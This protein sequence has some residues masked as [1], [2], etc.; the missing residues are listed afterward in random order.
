MIIDKKLVQDI[1]HLG[2]LE[3]SPA[4]EEEMANELNKI[5]DWMEQLNEVDTT[6][7]EPLIHIS[8]ELN[9]LRE[10]EEGNI[11][12]HDKALK[13]APKKDS[14]YFRVPKVIE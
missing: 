1:A 14:N 2:R 7:I 13:N 6:G 4:K 5:V 11:L 10:D 12:A 8:T 3:V 9:V